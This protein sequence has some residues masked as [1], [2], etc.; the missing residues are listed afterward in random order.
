MEIKVQLYNFSLVK[1]SE[2]KFAHTAEN[3]NKYMLLD[4][5]AQ[6]A[7]AAF[8]RQ[9]VNVIKPVFENSK[10]YKDLAAAIESGIIDKTTGVSSKPVEGKH[11]AKVPAGFSYQT[12]NKKN[13][14]VYTM[15][16]VSFMIFGDENY[17]AAKAAAIRAARTRIGD[18]ADVA[19]DIAANT[20]F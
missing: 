16:T 13:G 8:G 6:N 11:F 14:Q 15:S 9:S 10:V 12:T 17:E 4:C 18:D 19:A 3:G 2:G 20:S 7:A 5:I 1:T